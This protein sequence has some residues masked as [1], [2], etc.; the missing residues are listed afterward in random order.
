MQAA[1][2][3][4]HRH[5]IPPRPIAIRCEPGGYGVRFGL[6]EAEDERLPCPVFETLPEALAFVAALDEARG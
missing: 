5:A 2:E 6:T 1:A 4:A 3:T